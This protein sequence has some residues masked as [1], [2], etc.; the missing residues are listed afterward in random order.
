MCLAIPAKIIELHDNE[1]AVVDI[2][3][4]HKE[5]NIFLLPDLKLSDYVIVHVGYAL[6]RVDEDEAA[7]TL[8]L[9]AE[10]GEQATGGV[11]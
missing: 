4:V 7:K 2:G 3:G 10:M 6:S 9:F 11:P 8:Q 1:S 5:V